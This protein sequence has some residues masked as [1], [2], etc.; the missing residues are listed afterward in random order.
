MPRAI[1]TVV[2]LLALGACS[3]P[4][5]FVVRVT[6]DELQR[7]VDRRFPERIRGLV[8][9]VRLESPAIAL[10]PGT[11][12]LEL[13]FRATGLVAGVSVGY[14]LSAVTG[15]IRYDRNRAEFL[16]TD[17]H[18]IRFDAS[19]IP[20]KYFEPA[21]SIVDNFVNRALPAIPLYRLDKSKHPTKH[22][23]LKKAWICEGELC[24]EMGI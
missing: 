22:A 17:P 19:H 1:A 20:K 18:V 5:R 7:R 2:A 6:Q 16:L 23:L 12:R 9:E 8:F 4:G 21:R 13:T 15:G 11:D 14:A 10:N 3:A 24:L